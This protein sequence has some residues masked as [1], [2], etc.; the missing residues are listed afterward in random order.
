MCNYTLPSTPP[1]L[2]AS[3]L[4]SCRRRHARR[5]PVIGSAY[6]KL[7]RL[8]LF[9]FF[10]PFLPSS[11]HFRQQAETTGRLAFTSSRC[12]RRCE[13]VFR[14]ARRARAGVLESRGAAPPMTDS[15]VGSEGLLHAGR[16]MRAT[17]HSNCLLLSS[18]RLLAAGV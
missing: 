5:C 3:N 13:E 6:L 17:F 10:F 15:C 4:A 1:P 8:R 7:P 18:S 12:A 14:A 2:L 11:L 9:S 16:L